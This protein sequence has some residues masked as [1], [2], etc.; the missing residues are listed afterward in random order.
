VAVA[1]SLSKTADLGATQRPSAR[2][3]PT[4]IPAPPF[5]ILRP[6]WLPEP[7]TVRE[8]PIPGPQPSDG[9]GVI[10][11]FDPHPDTLPSQVLMTLRETPKAASSAVAIPDPQVAQEMIGG[12]DVTIV[13]R[14]DTWVSLSWAQGDVALTLTNPARYTPDQLRR[15]VASVQ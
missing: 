1:A 10:L 8:Q 13:R 15:I 9:A 2:P 3:M 7:L 11:G 6:M 12:H 14:G 5:T 4:A